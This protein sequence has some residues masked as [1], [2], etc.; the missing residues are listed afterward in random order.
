M[1][2]NREDRMKDERM[3]ARKERVKKC[4]R[5]TIITG[6]IPLVFTKNHDPKIEIKQKDQEIGK[7][8]CYKEK[9]IVMF[10]PPNT[11]TET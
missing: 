4:F 8:N 7:K 5:A 1:E 6:E 11:H 10:N 3:K 2:R 9:R